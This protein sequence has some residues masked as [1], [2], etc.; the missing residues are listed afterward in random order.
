MLLFPKHRSHHQ[1]RL[2]IRARGSISPPCEFNALMCCSLPDLCF[3]VCSVLDHDELRYLCS[4]DSRPC[5]RVQWLKV[6]HSLTSLPTHTTAATL[7]H[8]LIA[9]V[10]SRRCSPASLPDSAGD[11]FYR[12]WTAGCTKPKYR[13]VFASLWLCSRRRSEHGAT[14]PCSGVPVPCGMLHSFRAR[15]GY[16]GH[17]LF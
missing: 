17:N 2:M 10:I 3:C 5:T 1:R 7:N 16:C 6:T 12:G 4:V 13:I 14:P 11:V 8:V 15:G 9:H